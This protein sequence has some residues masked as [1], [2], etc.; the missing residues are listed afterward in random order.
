MITNVKADY[1]QIGDGKLY[2]EVEGEGETLLLNHAGFIDSGMWDDQ[3]D[4]LAEHYNLIRYDMRGY[5]KSDPL[6]APADRRDDL[7]QL[8]D[9]LN[10]QRAALLG[11][12]MGGEIALDFALEYPER[13]SA[14]ITVSA[15]PSGFEM[16]G[17]PPRYMMDMIEAFKKDELDRVADLQIRIWVDGEHREP[18][19]VDA[20]MR[21]HAAAMNKIPVQRRTWAMDMEPVNPLNPPAVSRLKDIHVP[22]LLIAGALD[23]SE[24]IRAAGVMEKE[25]KG[26]KKV[27]IE[28]AAHVPNMDQ[29]EEFNRIVLDF[30]GDIK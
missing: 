15:V 14:L 10:I 30:L 21:Q 9:H 12:S 11:C 23:N 17:E 2:Y 13:V 22:T 4:V 19:Q 8:L 26:A 3:W 18:N 6:K 25:I 29:P 5:G 28:D 7:R 27:V 20:K 24:I 16:K 1:V